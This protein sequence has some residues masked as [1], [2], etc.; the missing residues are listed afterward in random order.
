MSKLKT[1]F[2]IF[3]LF[4]GN[5]CASNTI[6]KTILTNKDYEKILSNAKKMLILPVAIE[7]NIIGIGG[8]RER[9]YEYEDNLE[10]IINDV[11]M[12]K[13]RQNGYEVELLGNREII[14]K[15]LFSVFMPLQDRISDVFY[16]L[17][18]LKN[19]QEKEDF[20]INHNVGSNATKLGALTNSDVI[21]FAEYHGVIK[22]SGH[23][24][25]DI[26]MDFFLQ[27]EQFEKPE[28]STLL[29]AF[30]N[31]NNA[32]IL[33]SNVAKTHQ[34]PFDSTFDNMSHDEIDHY[35]INELIEILLKRFPKK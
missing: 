27:T 16:E 25:K 9:V 1:I 19:T 26:M 28:E 4:I 24:V 15:K 34:D 23:R 11:L 30:I 8:V 2:I 29:L 6:K 20:L 35:N 31:A 18:L 7:V 33:W 14:N 22:T 32:D 21:I 17:S 13:I 5:S 12:E 3:I 10:N